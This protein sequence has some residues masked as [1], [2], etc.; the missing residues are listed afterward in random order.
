MLDILKV[1]GF[2]TPLTLFRRFFL[3]RNKILIARIV[4]MNVFTWKYIAK[5]YNLDSVDLA[6]WVGHVDE[7]KHVPRRL[8]P[9]HCRKEC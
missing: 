9:L 3:A 8:V 7:E 1:K 4:A 5:G 6:Q 2:S